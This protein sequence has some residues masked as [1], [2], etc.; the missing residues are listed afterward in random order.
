MPCRSAPFRCFA[1]IALVLLA[2]CAAAPGMGQHPGDPYEASNRAALEQ[3]LW[4][5]DNAIEPLVRAYRWAVPDPLRQGVSNFFDNLATPRILVNDL[6][7]AEWERAAETASRFA[8]NST[9]GFGGLFDRAAQM[10]IARHDE[11]FGQTL[12]VYGVGEQPYLV[13]QLLGPTNPRDTAGYLVDLALDPVNYLLFPV[14]A[15]ANV[16]GSTF[17]RFSRDPDRI[18]ALRAESIDVYATLRGAHRQQRAH[19]IRNGTPPADAFDELD[20]P[21]EADTGASLPAL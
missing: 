13:F 17:E 12:A 1:I 21:A 7:Q 2:G 3:N 11:D 5:Y 4:L 16:T 19:E 8:I 6:L 18:A 20:D 15:A 14:G 9:I 10:G